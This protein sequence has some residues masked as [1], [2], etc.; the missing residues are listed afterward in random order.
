MSW[1]EIGRPWAAGAMIAAALLGFSPASA[2][3]PNAAPPARVQAIS[4]APERVTLT[5]G[6]GELYVTSAPFAK[7]SVTDEKVVEVAP[8]SDRD[9]LF[10]PK[11]VGSTNVFLFDNRNALIAKLDVSVRSAGIQMQDVRAKTD[12]NSQQIVT[13][14]NR[15]YDPTGHGTLVKPDLFQCNASN[16]QNVGNEAL[17]DPGPTSP[18]PAAPKEGAKTGP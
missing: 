13:V 15:I 11:G 7:I 8:Q 10:N 14:Y 4:T 12:G 9:F 6:K 2:Q 18:A 3:D 1:A 5:M 17:V 16:C